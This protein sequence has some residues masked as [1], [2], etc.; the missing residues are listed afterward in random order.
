M[1]RQFEQKVRELSAIRRIGDALAY[2]MEMG[3]VCTAVL[4]A[5]VEGLDAEGGV[6]ILFEPSGQVPMAEVVPPAYPRGEANPFYPSGEMIDWV[7][8]EKR[9]LVIEDASQETRF[10][11]SE[12]PAGGSAMT[13]PLICRDV[14]IGVVN[15]GHCEANALR[16]EQIPAAHLMSSQAAIALENV[17]LVHELI[18]MNECL[19][20]KV[21]E[22]TRSL[23]VTNQKLMELQDQLVQAETMKVVGQFTAGI[24]H[25]L[26][27]PL[28][29]ILST[30]DL[31][32][33][34]GDGNNRVTGYAEK[35]LQQGSRMAEIIENLMEKCYKTQRQELERLDIN[36]ILAKELSFMEGNLDFKHNVVRECDFDEDLP[37]IEGFYGDFSQTFVNLINNA[38]D[39]MYE[40]ESKRLKIST[41]HDEE[42]IYV[43][44]QD[45]GC[46]IPEEEQKKIFDFSFS[47]KPAV[48][49]D[50][51]PPG[52][53]I[54]LFNSKY[55]MSR[56]GAQIRVKSRPGETVFTVCIPI[57]REGVI[58]ETDEIRPPGGG[59]RRWAEKRS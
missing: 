46:G 45:N 23:Q 15:L 17:K 1:S 40:T 56:Y 3:R 14:T 22:R 58:G 11:P 4:D 6:L 26:R 44:I 7:L 18:A 57:R 41:R 30:A 5:V 47:T 34:Y 10:P 33:L 29:V 27:T 24:G 43:A 35:I 49:Q 52:M 37:R 2:P 50:G 59:S 19:E 51:R 31:I 36:Q 21:L 39:A 12:R 8:R 16:S 54:G 9:P 55:L 32:K 28:S 48:R 20:E 42:Y 38:V 13:L 25:N 53:G